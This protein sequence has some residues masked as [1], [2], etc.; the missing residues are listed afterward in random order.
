VGVPAGIYEWTAE[1]EGFAVTVM[2]AVLGRGG[3]S[4]TWLNVALLP[5]AAKTAGGGDF[6]E[7][8]FRRPPLAESSDDYALARLYKELPLVI[9]V[10]GGE[11]DEAAVRGIADALNERWGVGIYDVARGDDEPA[12]VIT[13]GGAGD[14]FAIRPGV[15]RA[16]FRNQ[17]A[18]AGLIA[19]FL[20]RVVLSAGN[21]DDVSLADLT[22]D[23]A[24]AADL[25]DI[26]SIIYREPPNFNYAIFRG[27]RP[28][29]YNL[30][31]DIYLGVGGYGRHGVADEQG[32]P[33]KFPIE[34]Q[35]GQVSGAGGVAVAGI[36]GKVGWWFSGIWDAN[37]EAAR[38]EEVAARKVLRR[39][40]S[41]YFHGGY[42]WQV[43]RAITVMPFG[44][45]RRLSVRGAFASAA[46]RGN[47][48]VL[49]PVEMDYTTLYAGPEVGAGATFHPGPSGLAFTAEYGRVM[50]REGFNVAE[51]GVGAVNRAGV[52]TFA[53]ARCFWGP[54]FD[55]YYGGLAM[56]F[57][58]PVE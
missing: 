29:L 49:A 28:T 32:A 20:R 26:I 46:V 6:R 19:A 23:S 45:Y 16:S 14:E 52:G 2:P 34:Y 12:V 55:Y 4:D 35:L 39:N 30:L 25:D 17:G 7:L 50:G 53:Y 36:W 42:R 38:A 31:G 33:V 40:T 18:E 15:S 47:P 8:F 37:A 1:A 41:T 13:L 27:G 24:L 3:E 48:F 44:G 56:K 58:V 51:G 57:D 11:E 22:D 10:V 5:T 43:A 9:G 21:S 54:A